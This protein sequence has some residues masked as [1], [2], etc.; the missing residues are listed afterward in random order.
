MTSRTMTRA[1]QST[2]V[3]FSMK[4]KGGCVVVILYFCSL[5]L[6]DLLRAC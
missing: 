4:P 3:C 1:G 2:E 5:A 6:C